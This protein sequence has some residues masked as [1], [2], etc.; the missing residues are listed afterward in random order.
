MLKII[1]ILLM[2]SMLLGCSSKHNPSSTNGH[3]YGV[4]YRHIKML[5][6]NEK[7]I[8][9]GTTTGA[10]L[11]I[12]TGT[13]MG[14]SSG[15]VRGAV[16]GGIVGG[17]TGALAGNL[18]ARQEKQKAENKYMFQYME[19]L[20]GDIK[21]LN[22]I[23]VAAT[24][25]LECYDAQFEFLLDDIRNRMITRYDAENRFEEIIQGRDEAIKLLG[26]VETHGRDLEKQ[27]EMAF[28]DNEQNRA[29][30][31]KS[32]NNDPEYDAAKRKK[33]ILTSKIDDI[34]KKRQEETNKKRTY[35]R[36]F[37]ANLEDIDI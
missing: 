37:S 8:T 23:T 29:K 12:L 20:E 32:A 1:P 16:V 24:R 5:K 2:V 27:Y 19:D 14:M 33:Q 22:I 35:Q 31:S 26:E 9:T 7:N 28:I 34:S 15:N 30:R 6:D 21:N 10:L 25:S 17:A 4:C 3:Y 18:H 13:L 36:D 11:G